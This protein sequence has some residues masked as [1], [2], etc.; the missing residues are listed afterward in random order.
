MKQIFHRIKRRL[1]ISQ[2]AKSSPDALIRRGLHWLLPTF[3]RAAKYS[4]AYR[5][6][7]AEAGVDPAT[8]KTPADFVARCPVLDKSNTFNRFGVEQLLC[9]DVPRDELAAVLTSS[10]HGAG[11]FALGLSTRKQFRHAPQ[12][13]DLGLEMAFA[14]DSRRTLLINCLPMGV[15][16]SSDVVCVA[17]VSV[18][19]DMACAIVQQAG[20]LF[21]QIILCGDPLFLKRLCDYSEAIGVDWRQ[22]RLHVIVGEETFPE[23]FRDYLAGALHIQIDATDGGLIGSSMGI[24]ELGLNLFNETRETVALRRACIQNPALLEKLTGVDPAVSPAPTFLVYNPLRTFIEVINPD[25]HGV[26]DLVV[27]VMDKAAP[28]PLMRYKTGDR[29]QLIAPATLSEVAAAVPGGLALPTL[30]LIS[31]H[32]RATDQLPG[33]GHV[34]LFKEAL[35]RN[36][37]MACHLSGAHRISIESDGIRWEV[38]AVSDTTADLADLANSLQL[39]LTPRFCSTLQVICHAY[40]DFPYSKTIDYERKFLYWVPQK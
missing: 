8:I 20:N 24:G 21:E 22:H 5:T 7:L 32:G 17:N 2:L 9:E 36:P 37:A 18:R 40:V 12:L 28:I 30:P 27:T 14:I 16:F 39:D 13:I 4:P 29:M 25:A 10:G 38:Q 23:A 11:G 33:G 26:G 6:L 19:E 1:I 3:R 35:Y 34:D 31:L 15:T